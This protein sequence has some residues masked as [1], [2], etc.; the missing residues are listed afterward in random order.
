MLVV[1]MVVDFRDIGVLYGVTRRIESKPGRVQL[2]SDRCV[3][4]DGKTLESLERGRTNADS[5]GIDLSNV[6]GANLKE[7]SSRIMVLDDSLLQRFGRDGARDG[8]GTG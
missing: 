5:G 4:S 3:V 2:V 7:L 8:N 1:E 6:G